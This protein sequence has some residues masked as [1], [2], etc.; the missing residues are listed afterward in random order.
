[1]FDNKIGEK[2]ARLRKEKGLTQKEL[3]EKL[4]VTDKAVSKWERGLSLPDITLLEKL[5]K[6][7]DIDIYD[8]FGL[9]ERN[10]DDVLKVIKEEKSKLEKQFRKKVIV[11]LGVVIIIIL[12]F[13]FKT[14]PFG[15]VIE[16]FRYAHYDNKLI[17]LGVPKFSFL[18]QNN[19][20]NYSFKSFRGKEVLKNEV[21]DFLNTLEF[22]TC[23]D[24]VY[25]YDK[26]SDVTIIN[27]DVIGN[28]VYSTV[29]YSVRSGNYC[30]KFKVA[31]Y[32]NILG[33]L[34]KRRYTDNDD[35]YIDITFS[36]K[37]DTL[38]TAHLIAIDKKTDE[39]LEESSGSFEIKDNK[40]I[41]F[42]EKINEESIDVPNKSVFNIKDK[43]LILEDNYFYDFMSEV[44]L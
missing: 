44:V 35:I 26:S 41:Y 10:K 37:E 20:N 17:N 14:F 12:I 7:L 25:Y 38:F 36:Y 40:L 34:N 29:S 13:L 32:G 6:E 11:I 31:E 21:K 28:L 8:L 42:R 9:E 4:F 22:T 19:E 33:G 39:V 15:Y 18:M 1:M 27:Y 43:K 16:H 2:I 5:A 24:T 30:D 23:N 3:G